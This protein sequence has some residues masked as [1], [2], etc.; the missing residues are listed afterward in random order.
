MLLLLRNA[1]NCLRVRGIY[2]D[3]QL[4][5]DVPAEFEEVFVFMDYCD[6]RLESI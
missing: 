4:A 6:T 1:R 2:F 5:V 3:D